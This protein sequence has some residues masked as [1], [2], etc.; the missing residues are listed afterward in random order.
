MGRIRLQ[1]KIERMRNRMQELADSLGL[2]DP[3]VVRASQQLDRLLN[4]YMGGVV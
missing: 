4:E 1:I 3:R 2:A